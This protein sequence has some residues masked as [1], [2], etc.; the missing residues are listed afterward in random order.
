MKSTVTSL[1]K[2]FLIRRNPP[3]RGTARQSGSVGH[4]K[5]KLNPSS[6][7]FYSPRISFGFVVSHLKTFSFFSFFFFLCIVLHFFRL[8]IC[9]ISELDS[10]YF[11]LF[12][13]F[14]GS[15]SK[16]V[17]SAW[18]H[19]QTV[20]RTWQRSG[21]LFFLMVSLELEWDFRLCLKSLAL[22]WP[23]ETHFVITQ[24][25]ET[26]S[27]GCLFENFLKGEPVPAFHKGGTLR[28]VFC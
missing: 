2:W 11:V 19:Q 9:R 12:F 3:S 26:S 15:L 21:N 8:C 1:D 28:R 7:L 13:I 25:M 27:E 20:W 22:I 10:L 5:S 14:N 6:A 4:H 24:L 17:H 16:S 18:W 23:Q